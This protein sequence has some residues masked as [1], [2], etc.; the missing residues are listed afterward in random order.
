MEKTFLSLK[1]GDEIF[2]TKISNSKVL[3]T[4]TGSV[5]KTKIARVVKTCDM[6][7]ASLSFQLPI[8]GKYAITVELDKSVYVSYNT[9]DE[10]SLDVDVFG[11]TKEAV[12]KKTLAISFNSFKF[13]I[14]YFLQRYEKCLIIPND[15][16]NI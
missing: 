12:L 6:T 5:F 7:R 13:H 8:N 14:V 3:M 16:S 15:I 1:E 2:F 11:M 10:V 4:I 9:S